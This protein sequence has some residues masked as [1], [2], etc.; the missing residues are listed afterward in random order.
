MNVKRYPNRLEDFLFLPEGFD[1]AD[2]EKYE[3]HACDMEQVLEMSR[4]A[5]EFCRQK[6]IEEKRAYY[7]SLCIEE[8]AYYL[9]LCIEEMAGNIIKFGFSDGKKHDID[10]RL[11][12]KEDELIVRIRDDCRL[13]NPKEWLEIHSEDEKT[14]NIGIRMI[15]QIAKDFNYINTL[16]MN[17]LIIRI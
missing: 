4:E 8:I 5:L 7:L 1:V 13:F 2:S 3:A 17:N 9:S 12:R 16:D 6:G 11:I 14:K 15:N 10:L